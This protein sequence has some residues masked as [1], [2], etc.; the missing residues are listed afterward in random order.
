MRSTRAPWNSSV[1]RRLLGD[2]HVGGPG[3][4]DGDAPGAAAPARASARVRQRAAAWKRASAC[5]AQRRARCT[6]ALVA[7]HE[8]VLAAGRD[9]LHDGGD[10]LGR[11]PAPKTTSGK[12][13][14][15][16]RW[17]STFA[18]PRSSKG[19]LFR[20]SAASRRSVPPARTCRSSSSRSSGPHAY[21][22]TL[23]GGELTHYRICALRGTAPLARRGRR[24]PATLS[25]SDAPF[26][27][28]ALSRRPTVARTER[29]YGGC[30]AVPAE[31]GPG[32]ASPSA[33]RGWVSSIMSPV[34]VGRP[35]PVLPDAGDPGGLRPAPL[36]HGLPLLPAPGPPRAAG[37][38][39]RSA[40]RA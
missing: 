39:A 18:K 2:R 19:R 11:L 12:P 28:V 8:H 35:R 24:G 23:T 14:R 40:C 7:R 10:L 33:A 9:A 37:A 26:G 16:A 36:R 17:W 22:S 38:A 30:R 3:A 32:G 15:S 4:D 13:R 27:A 21:P 34:R 25:R 6:S 5:A 31:A 20:R 1:T 29:W